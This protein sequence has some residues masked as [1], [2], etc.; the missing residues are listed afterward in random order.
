LRLP[1]RH[2]ALDSMELIKSAFVQRKVASISAQG[3][4]TE[5]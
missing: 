5:F 3:L 1:F 4:L 2:S